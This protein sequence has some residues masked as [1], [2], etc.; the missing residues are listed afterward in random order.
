MIENPKRTGKLL[1]RVLIF[2]MI[3][4][5]TKCCNKDQIALSVLQLLDGITDL[6]SAKEAIPYHE[7]DQCVDIANKFCSVLS[8]ASQEDISAYFVRTLSVCDS[9]FFILEKHHAKLTQSNLGCQT[10]EVKS[11]LIVE[12]NPPQSFSKHHFNLWMKAML[13]L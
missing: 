2:L 12:D 11:G 1:Y 8:R 7:I 3:Q 6:H 13:L 5:S 4:T 9:I 10:N